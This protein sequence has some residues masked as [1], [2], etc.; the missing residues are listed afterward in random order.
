[1]S[2][3]K[4]SELKNY[5]SEDTSDFDYILSDDTLKNKIIELW[6]NLFFSV[7]SKQ[8]GRWTKRI[9][10]NGGSYYGVVE[11]IEDE[12]YWGHINRGNTNFTA[13]THFKNEVN[14]LLLKDEINDTIKFDRDYT[15]NFNNIKKMFRYAE[16]YKTHLISDKNEFYWELREYCF[17]SWLAGQEH[18][19]DW[20]ENWKYYFPEAFA[21][22]MKDDLPGDPID[23]FNGHDCIMYVKGK[24]TGETI[25]CG[26][27]IKGV[28]KCELRG[29]DYYVRV[30][31][32]L[33]NYNDVILFVF[34]VPKE[35]EIYIFKNDKKSIERLTEYGKPVFK[36]P[37]KLF[38]KKVS[39][40]D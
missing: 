40:N 11:I 2:K 9:K 29:E 35:K 26:T 20:K 31:M 8:K 23:M 28:S 6:G 17:R 15:N 36:F 12:E 30:S 39:K 16:T 5:S 33:K 38:I 7:Y 10:E 32:T 1:M 19:K 27:Q 37:S 25:F 4:L 22:E 13:L 21:M 18:T 24:N 14:R 34:Y 3:T